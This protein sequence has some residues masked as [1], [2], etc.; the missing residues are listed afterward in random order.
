MNKKRV[1]LRSISISMA[2]TFC[3]VE[4]GYAFS[5][6]TQNLATRSSNPAVVEEAINIQFDAESEVLND[7]LVGVTSYR[8]IGKKYLRDKI[9]RAENPEIYLQTLLKMLQ[10]IKTPENFRR[11]FVK[12][13]E[14]LHRENLLIDNIHDFH[15][16]GVEATGI[17]AFGFGV[18][19][20]GRIQ[21]GFISLVKTLLAY[22]ADPQSRE[23][24]ID[25]KLLSSPP[26]SLPSSLFLP[27]KHFYT[28]ALIE[29]YKSRWVKSEWLPVEVRQQVTQTLVENLL[30]EE[31]PD[32]ILRY[33]NLFSGSHPDSADIVGAAVSSFL[34]HKSIQVQRTAKKVLGFEKVTNIDPSLVPIKKLGIGQFGDAYLVRQEDGELAVLKIAGGKFTAHAEWSKAEHYP[35][36]QMVAEVTM[37]AKDV[38]SG[39]AIESFGYIPRLIKAY[40]SE[41]IIP[42]GRTKAIL[43]K[44][45]EGKKV[46]KAIED[47]DITSEWLRAEILKMVELF[48]EK[49]VEIWDFG[50]PD[51]GGLDL[52][53]DQAGNLRFVDRGAVVPIIDGEPKWTV[54][55]DGFL[56]DLFGPP[57]VYKSA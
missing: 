57:L 31:S 29:I 12:Y 41:E 38:D 36:L 47:G 23:R 46:Q 48:K 15:R 37:T 33:L 27:Y 44:Y 50:D 32:R 13:P 7:I 8:R 34:N 51:F 11:V 6:K 35:A 20:F 53:I 10:I 43:V 55:L 2:L 18:T 40:P 25:E 54:A 21:P 4:L 24:I 39:N 17:I 3:M 42:P 56:L 9:R 49:N 22:S 1:L 30:E 52:L 14:S 5:V 19:E 26:L 45:V 28:Q 16:I